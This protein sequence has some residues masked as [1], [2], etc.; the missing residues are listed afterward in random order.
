[1]YSH[2]MYKSTQMRTLNCVCASVGL[3]A[4]I[5]IKW[6]DGVY[7]ITANEANAIHLLS[8]QSINFFVCLLFQTSSQLMA[9]TSIREYIYMAAIPF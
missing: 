9:I 6:P 5:K 2:V 3:V 4:I 8:S 7:M 1:M